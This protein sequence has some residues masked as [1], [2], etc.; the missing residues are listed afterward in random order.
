[1]IISDLPNDII[2]IIF[3]KLDKFSKV[4]LSLTCKELQSIVNVVHCKKSIN[5][6]FIKKDLL[7][8]YTCRILNRQFFIESYVLHGECEDCRCLGF[9]R[10]VTVD[11]FDPR[12]PQFKTICLE[13]CKLVN[14]PITISSHYSWNNIHRSQFLK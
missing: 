9:L 7:H 14:Y 2:Y 12:Y 8:K 6:F 11:D 3:S 10:E 5:D 13:K 4:S 1:M